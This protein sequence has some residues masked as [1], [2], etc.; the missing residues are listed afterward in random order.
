MTAAADNKGV[1]A[2][3]E[4]DHSAT[5]APGLPAVPPQPSEAVLPDAFRRALPRARRRAG[6][7]AA[8]EGREGDRRPGAGA[9]KGTKARRAAKPHAEACEYRPAQRA[10]DPARLGRAP[11]Q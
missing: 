5:R 10:Q 11:E 2:R 6:R 8:A 3:P 1:P 7:P 9:G 4:P